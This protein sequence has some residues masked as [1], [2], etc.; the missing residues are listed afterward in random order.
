M[1]GLPNSRGPDH[2]PVVE[3]FTPK[4]VGADIELGNFILGLERPG[5]TGYEASRALL[6]NVAG[7]PNRRPLGGGWSNGGYAGYSMGAAQGASTYN[8]QDWGRKFLPG[9][10]GCCYIDLDHLEICTPEVLGARDHVAV[11]HAMLRIARNAL[12]AANEQLPDDLTLIALANNSDGQGNSYGSHYSFLI[13][14]RLWDD[15]FHQKMHPMLFVL[16]AYQASSIVFTGQGKVGSENGQPPVDYQISQRADFFETL[17]GEQTTYRR[18]LV[19]ARNEPLCGSPCHGDGE[20]LP[21]DDLARLHTIFFDHTLCHVAG[22]LRTGVMQLVLAMIESGRSNPGLILE[23]PLSAL[24]E[25]SRDPDLRV[26]CKLSDGRIV[27]AVEHQLLFLQE[28]KSFVETDACAASVPDAADIVAVWQDTLVKLEKRDFEA[29]SGRLDWVLKRGLIE[30]AIGERPELT[31]DSPAI[32]HLDLMYGNL[33][34]RMGLY[35]ACER[36]GVVERLVS[37]DEIERFV[38]N[39]PEDTRAWMRAMLLRKAGADA[40]EAVDWDKISFWTRRDGVAWRR[41]RTLRLDNPLGFTRADCEISLQEAESLDD[42]LDD[43]GASD[44]SGCSPGV[45]AHNSNG[46][47]HERPGSGVLPGPGNPARTFGSN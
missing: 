40:I 37:D 42:L 32:K 31:W 12:D 17:V 14:R 16:L 33:D 15:L 25:W 19:N 9:N 8:V 35:W 39:P 26:R 22:Y 43:L 20:S 7:V 34:E 46:R 2:D 41:C 21:G 1:S 4:L 38:C 23:D 36:S 29:L 3:S 24:H 44:P 27:T 10:G 28:V 18:P 5:G 11:C 13:S 45:L 6:R 30:R 47:E